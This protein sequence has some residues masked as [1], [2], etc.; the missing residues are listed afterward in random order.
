MIFPEHFEMI[1]L[2]SDVFFGKCYLKM[3]F[4]LEHD[5]F[6]E[7]GWG[8]GEKFVGVDGCHDGKVEGGRWKVKG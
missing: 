6:V 1:I 7:S 3:G 8:V 4:V 2:K 5:E